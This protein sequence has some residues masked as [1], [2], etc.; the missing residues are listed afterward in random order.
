MNRIAGIG[1]AAAGFVIALLGILKV[2]PGWTGAGIALLIVGVLVVGLSFIKPPDTEG[3][4]RMSTGSTL[5]NIFVSPSEVFRNLRFHPRWL[6]ALL[7][8]VLLTSVY[9]TLFTNKVTPERIVGFTVDKTLEMGF[10]DENAK[11][12][13]EK[14]RQTQIDDAKN[15]ITRAGTAVAGGAA[16]VIMNALTA[17]LLFVAVLVM[18]GKI[19]YLQAFATAVYASFPVTTILMILNIIILQVKDVDSIHPLLGQRTLVQDNLGF[20]FAAAEHPILYTLIASLSLLGFYWVW[21][22]ATGLKNAGEKV[23]GTAAWGGA[24]GF[25]SILVLFGLL[26]AAIFPSFIS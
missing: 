17:L 22:I 1:T 21:L 16:A 2:L 19:N 12:E 8:T 10:L 4:E 15:P 11:R 6:V 9:L 26:M 20:L 23:S 3:V 24:I 14:T 13:I 25:Y 5:L 18:G 7:L